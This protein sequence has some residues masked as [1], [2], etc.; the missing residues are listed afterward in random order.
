MARRKMI[1]KEKERALKA[2]E[3]ALM[4]ARRAATAVAMAKLEK[5]AAYRALR[6]RVLVGQSCLFNDPAFWAAE[7]K[8]AEAKKAA[9]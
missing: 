1:I 2:A 7:R 4:A 3:R 8:K 6:R 9:S 5:T